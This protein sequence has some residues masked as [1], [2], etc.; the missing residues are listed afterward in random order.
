MSGAEK[1]REEEEVELKSE[2]KGVTN[3]WWRV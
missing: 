2:T 3:R 1:D